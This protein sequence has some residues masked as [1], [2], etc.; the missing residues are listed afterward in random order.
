MTEIPCT[1]I[2]SGIQRGK[3]RFIIVMTGLTCPGVE[4]IAE[5]CC[6]Y[7][8]IPEFRVHET[9]RRAMDIFLRQRNIQYLLTGIEFDPGIRD[10]R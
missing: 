9:T 4:A 8:A 1:K 10:A 7:T 6:W 5:K 3:Q 2:K